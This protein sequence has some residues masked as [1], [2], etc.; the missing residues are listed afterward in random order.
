MFYGRRFFHSFGNKTSPRK[1]IRILNREFQYRYTSYLLILIT[2]AIVFF[3]VPI[4]Y[5]V[6]Q[7]Y[8]MFFDL[9]YQT[10][11]DLLPHLEREVVSLNNY[12]IAGGFA[13]LCFCGLMG[14]R[15]TSRLV[16]PV[17]L[18]ESHL[19]DIT[20]GRWTSP[21]LRLRDSD[22][23]KELTKS[24]NYFY[25]SLRSLTESEVKQLEKIKVDHKDL[26]SSRI[27]KKLIN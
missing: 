27:L 10:S 18:M 22:E 24:Y 3:G 19:R 16:G 6:N 14:L 25:R 21:T 26:E 15:I 20:K 2:N 7:N 17:A 9:A 4:Y 5:F 13:L 8:Q 11:P 1:K 12:L 23:F